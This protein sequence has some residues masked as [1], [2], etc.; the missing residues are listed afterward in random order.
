MTRGVLAHR[1]G[2]GAQ[3][4]LYYERIGLLDEPRRN[5]AGHRVYEPEDLTRLVLIRRAQEIGFSL[6]DIRELLSL[7]L[8][9]VAECSQV[10]RRAARRLVDVRN[11]IRDLERMEQGLKELIASCRE[12]PFKASCPVYE[13]LERTDGSL[14]SER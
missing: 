9:E 1:S 5:R 2:I 8:Q 3:T 4:I 10:E 14:A 12:N 6:E 7:R 11:R 13:V